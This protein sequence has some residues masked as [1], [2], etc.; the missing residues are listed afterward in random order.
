MISAAAHSLGGIV[1]PTEVGAAV[2]PPVT[3]LEVFSQTVANAV[4]ESAVKQG[5]NKEPITD[6][7]Q[8]VAHLKWVPEYKTVQ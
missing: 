5:I 2:L 7:K 4:A 1:D 3:Q 6:I 8:A